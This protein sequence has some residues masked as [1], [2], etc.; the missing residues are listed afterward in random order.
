M[1][2]RGI[3]TH[4]IYGTFDAGVDVVVRN[5]GSASSGAFA[6][7]PNVSVDTQDALDHS[8][9]GTAAAQYVI[10]R[11]TA[12]LTDWHAPAVSAVS[13]G[14]VAKPKAETKTERAIQ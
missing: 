6:H 12:L 3:Q 5:F 8:L 9:R 4:L 2:A 13:A 7:L 10:D 1:S 14:A 11:C